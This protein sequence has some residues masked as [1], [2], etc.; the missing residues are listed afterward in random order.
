MGQ[1]L[2]QIHYIEGENF[3]L[4]TTRNEKQPPFVTSAAPTDKNLEVINIWY[5]NLSNSAL[6]VSL[7]AVPVLVRIKC[8]RVFTKPPE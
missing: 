5:R 1:S 4:M 7:H 6:L 2:K 8:F 3:E